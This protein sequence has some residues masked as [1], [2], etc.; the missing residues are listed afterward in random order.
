MGFARDKYPRDNG[1]PRPS[2]III[3]I[4]ISSR[5]TYGMSKPISERRLA[6]NRAN[7][8]KSTGPRTPQGK[9]RSSMNA[10]V[11]GLA[12]R[13][14]VLPNEDRAAFDAFARALR[15]DLR[16]RGPVQELLVNEVI[17]AA[18]KLRRAGDAE[19]RVV[20]HA[21][22]RYA[23]PN[24]RVTPG[25]LLADALADDP[26]AEPFRNLERYSDKA[27]RAFFTALRRLYRAQ[28]FAPLPGSEP[29]T[30]CGAGTS[31][32]TP[33]PGPNFGCD[34]APRPPKDAPPAPVRA[35]NPFRPVFSGDSETAGPAGLN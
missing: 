14:V 5:I 16:P 6:A 1:L 25:M 19:D 8:K 20:R 17:D 7:A 10:L 26:R 11:H 15:K 28:K 12:A 9:A 13:R 31:D 35:T 27:Q 32:L 34:H 4:T 33:M 24:R 22:L 18:W 29:I 2:K 21:L 23:G 3:A 30:H